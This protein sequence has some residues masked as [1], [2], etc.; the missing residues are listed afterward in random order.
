ML[1]ELLGILGMC[2][3]HHCAHI[4]QRFVS[5]LNDFIDIQATV[6]HTYEHI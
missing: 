3:L 5:I 2:A 4:L 1:S 6:R